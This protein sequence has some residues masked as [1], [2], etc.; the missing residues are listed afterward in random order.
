MEM[1]MSNPMHTVQTFDLAQQQMLVLEG[2]RGARVR[3]LGGAA[4]LTSEGDLGDRVLEAG[5]ELA[6]AR[7]RTLIEALG[8]LRV[9]VWTAPAPATAFLRH[10]GSALRR[11]LRRWQL[12]PVTGEWAA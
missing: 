6:L 12:G 3:V 8:P 10:A 7:G 1:D 9:Q 2:G 4:W 5:A 11:Q